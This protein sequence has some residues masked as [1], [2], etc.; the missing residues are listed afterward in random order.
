MPLPKKDRNG[1]HRVRKRTPDDL[2]EQ[3][4][5]LYGQRYEVKLFIPARTPAQKAQQQ[6]ADW[7]GDFTGRLSDTRAASR[8]LVRRDNVVTLG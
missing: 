6:H 7:L 2:R 5:R 1:N 4:G 8:P 3:F